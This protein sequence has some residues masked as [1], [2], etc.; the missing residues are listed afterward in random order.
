LQKDK[1]STGTLSPGVKLSGPEAEIQRVFVNLHC[2]WRLDGLR[3]GQAGLDSRQSQD[4]SLLH[5]VQTGSG[6]HP[7]S[8]PMSAGASGGLKPLQI[9]IFFMMP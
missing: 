6:P 5:N 2:P 8:Y 7:A 3:V 1:M 4:V 9:I